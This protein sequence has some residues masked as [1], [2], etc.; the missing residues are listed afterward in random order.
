MGDLIGFEGYLNTSTPFQAGEHNALW[1]TERRYNDFSFGN[2]EI[3]K[4][5]YPRFYGDDGNEVTNL[6]TELVGCRDSEFDQYGEV[7]A[8]GNYPEWQRQISKFAFVQDRLREW[9]SDVRAKI[10]HFSCLT[11]SM[12]DIDGFRIDKGLTVT[13]D[14]QAEWSKAMRECARKHNK[15]NFYI[16]GE[17][18]AGNT[19]G[20]VYIGR[21][22]SPSQI[23]DNVTQAVTLTNKSDSKYFIRDAGLSAFD[24]AAFHYTVYR[25]LTRFLGQADYLFPSFSIFLL[26]VITE[27]TGLLKLPAIPRWTGWI[28]GMSL[29]RRTI[30]STRILASLILDICTE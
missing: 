12:L 3:A 2:N 22:R 5:T 21:G 20:S 9:R 17:I 29:H 7:A 19:F 24:G 11:I 15:T 6:T 18:V 1:K 28:S 25:G 4:C 26:T 27:W 13:V 10:E 8:F 23:V 14:A 30:W 16:A